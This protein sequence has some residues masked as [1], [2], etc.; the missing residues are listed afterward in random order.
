MHVA[1]DL[2]SA[3]LVALPELGAR[4]ASLRLIAVG[5]SHDSMADHRLQA[6]IVEL[7]AGHPGGTAVG[8]EMLHRSHQ[9]ALD[10][11]VAGTLTE[12]EMLAA[13]DWKTTWGFD[14]NLYAGIFR[15]ARARGVPI[16]GLNLPREVVRAVSKHGLANVPPEIK[17]QLPAE[18]D[19]TQAAHRARVSES[20]AHPGHAPMSPERLDRMYQ[21]MC[22]WDEAMADRS[23]TF[24]AEHK[25]LARIVVIAGRGHVEN[26][27]G[28]PARA[29]R[30]GLST[31]AVVL[32]SALDGGHVGRL[33]ADLLRPHSRYVVFV[34]P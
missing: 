27:D 33:R 8:L 20:F 30:R 29:A 34:A 14:W 19:L 10:R 25:D 1:V 22:V 5:E 24:L 15:A 28:I 13:V 18:I 12:P 23:A 7:V 31:W 21:S 32:P 26:G 6:A 3:S 11:Y 17:A 4:L 16:V 2:E 9:E